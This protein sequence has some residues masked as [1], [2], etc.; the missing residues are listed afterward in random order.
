[1]VVTV[2]GSSHGVPWTR[3]WPCVPSRAAAW[4][5]DVGLLTFQTDRALRPRR[6]YQL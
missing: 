6:H 3:R 4:T 1:M 2:M 5:A